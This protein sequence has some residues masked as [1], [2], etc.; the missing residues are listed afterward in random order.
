MS[1]FKTSFVFSGINFKIRKIHVKCIEDTSDIIHVN[2]IEDTS[3]IIHVNCNIKKGKKTST[4][5]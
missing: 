2:C 3:D 4:I 1:E 5:P